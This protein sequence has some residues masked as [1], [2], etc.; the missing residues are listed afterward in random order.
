MKK[1]TSIITLFLI[2][3]WFS[4]CSAFATTCD[5]CG[6]IVSGNVKFCSECGANVSQNEN[7]EET[8]LKKLSGDE[9]YDAVSASVVTITAKSSQYTSTGTGFFLH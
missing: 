3:A 2:I 6:A 8:E 7:N 4:S 5:K 1:I 9:I